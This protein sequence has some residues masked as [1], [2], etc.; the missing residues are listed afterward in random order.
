MRASF[1]PGLRPGR[2]GVAVLP[3]LVL[4]RAVIGRLAEDWPAAEV[5]RRAS[6]APINRLVRDNGQQRCFGAWC[7]IKKWRRLSC[8]SCSSSQQPLRGS[9]AMRSFERDRFSPSGRGLHG[10]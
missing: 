9:E 1:L 2:R 4:H 8:L 7:R 10:T 6:P 5:T 3:P